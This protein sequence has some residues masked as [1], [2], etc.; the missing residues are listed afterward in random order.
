MLV[1]SQVVLSLQL[2]FA[3]V[4]LISL[5]GK[6]GLMGD[7]VNAWWT[8]ALSWF[9]FVVISGANLWMVGQALFG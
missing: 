2:P 1:G 8:A 7:F 9:L 5:T 6:R 4:P 3:M